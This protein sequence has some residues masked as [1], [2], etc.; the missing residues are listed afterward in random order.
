MSF[1]ESISLLACSAMDTQSSECAVIVDSLRYGVH[2]T[3]DSRLNLSNTAHLTNRLDKMA[4]ELIW[5]ENF[6]FAAWGCSACAWIFPN[7]GEPVSGRPPAKVKEP[8][9]KHECAK[10]PRP[11]R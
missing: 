2:L 5:L 10:F 7:P 6:T 11:R 3:L 4:R 1:A 9:D 8:F